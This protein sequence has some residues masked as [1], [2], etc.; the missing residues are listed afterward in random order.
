MPR[1]TCLICKTSVDYEAP[2]PAVYPF[3]SDRCKLIDLG[4]WF[5]EEYSLEDGPTLGTTSLADEDPGAE[6]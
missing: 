3:C 5:N 6:A 4:R 1:Y 2:A